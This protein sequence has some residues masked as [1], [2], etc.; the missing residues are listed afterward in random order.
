MVR[1]RARRAAV[2]VAPPS[3]GV[4]AAQPPRRRVM[5]SSRASLARWPSSSVALR[6]ERLDLVSYGQAGQVAA[7]G[8]VPGVSGWPGVF[9][10][11]LVPGADSLPGGVPASVRARTAWPLAVRGHGR[12]L[13][14]GHAARDHGSRNIQQ[15][16]PI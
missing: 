3:A 11:G 10:C 16:T 15:A 6:G 5:R 7:I 12:R 2:K 14:G 1:T 8:N 4:F 13:C 9:S